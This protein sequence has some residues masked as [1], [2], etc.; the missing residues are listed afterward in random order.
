MQN[1]NICSTESIIDEEGTHRKNVNNV[2]RPSAV[3]ACI[4]GLQSVLSVECIPLLFALL[5][6]SKNTLRHKSPLSRSGRFV[7]VD[8]VWHLILL[9]VQNHQVQLLVLSKFDLSSKYYRIENSVLDQHLFSI[10]NIELG[11]FINRTQ[12]WTLQRQEGST[13][14]FVVFPRCYSYPYAEA[15]S[16]LR[17]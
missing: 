6:L 9:W 14:T 16:F 10:L 8:L 4:P 7:W 13:I 2:H 15:L 1:A 3:K 5:S 11:Y 12:I 17:S